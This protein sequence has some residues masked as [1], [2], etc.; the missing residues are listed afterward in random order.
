MGLGCFLLVINNFRYF[1]ENILYRI[2]RGNVE[3]SIGYGFFV[4]QNIFQVPSQRIFRY[5]L[6]T[7][8]NISCNTGYK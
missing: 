4:F 1:Y 7:V 2:G 8:C 5:T 6:V 3:K